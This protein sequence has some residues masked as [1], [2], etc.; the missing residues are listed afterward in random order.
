MDAAVAVGAVLAVVEPCSTGLGGDGFC[1]YYD[2]ASEKVH[3]V[4]GSGRA[5]R[6]LSLDAAQQAS[7]GPD[8]KVF[9]PY[10]AHTVTVPGVVA[11]WCDVLDKYGSGAVTVKDALARAVQLAEDGF[12]VSE[13]AAAFWKLTEAQLQERDTQRTL[14]TPDGAAPEAGALFRRPDTAAVLKAIQAHGRAGYYDGWV[15]EAVVAAVAAEGG[16]LSLADL[17]DHTTSYPEAISADF[18]GVRV[19][20]HPPNGQGI[21]ALIALNILTALERAGKIDLSAPG[22]EATHAMIEAL[23]LALADAARFV[24]DPDV[25]PVPVAELLSTAYAEARAAGVDLSKATADVQA[26]QPLK[27]SCTVSFQVV[28]AQGSAVSMVNSNYMG[29]GT[30][31]VPAGTGFTLQNRGYNFS[32][33]A[34]SPNCY[35]P[36]KR[37]YHT[38][39]PCI[40]TTPAGALHSTFT[41]MGGFMQPQGHVQHLVNLLRR[42]M[43]PQES[44]DRP[45][46]C[47][48]NDQY[49]G[50]YGVIAV[51]AACPEELVADLRRRG[52]SVEVVDG[53]GRGVVGR[54]QIIVR[55]PSGVLVGGSDARADGCAIGY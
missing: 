54:A 43:N 8:A 11:M 15:A 37:P 33:D 49:S 13:V 17:S 27:D 26:G 47:I 9:P 18:A 14:L 22:P 7:G 45:R 20:G 2:S 3:A 40:T 10:H 48:L 52:H 41:N 21:T 55:L 6:G 32:L 36:G 24:A 25:V 46:F 42:G 31:I 1:L 50:R 4:N 5:P 19:W 16:V 12:P 23:R 38:I 53:T 34:A 35:A 39:I 29:F 51:E 44:I 28:D 30:C